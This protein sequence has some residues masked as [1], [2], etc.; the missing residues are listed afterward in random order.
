VI[1]VIAEENEHWWKGELNG[2]QG[3]FPTNVC[4]RPIIFSPLLTYIPI[5]HVETLPPTSAPSRNPPPPPPPPSQ[6]SYSNPPPP[7]STGYHPPTLPSPSNP[8]PYPSPSKAYDSNPT[9]YTPPYQPYPSQQPYYAPPPPQQQPIVV[10]QESKG[11]FGGMG[12]K[13]TN[14]LV[15]G[16]GFGAGAAVGGELVSSIF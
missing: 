3:L 8:N 13:F 12:G 2:R 6:P 15:G 1:K 5:Q 14:S 4:V 11:K 16:L 9:P 10:Q 7:Q